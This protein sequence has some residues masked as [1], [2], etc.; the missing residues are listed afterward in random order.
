MLGFTKERKTLMW[1]SQKENRQ[2]S[3]LRERLQQTHDQADGLARQER[4]LRAELETA[5]L[6]SL[7]LHQRAVEEER[8][9][10]GES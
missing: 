9:L 8:D 10:G 1:K 5:L 6:A 4:D 3:D 7:E 2:I